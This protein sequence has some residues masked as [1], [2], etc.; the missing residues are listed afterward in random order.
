MP[1]N[2]NKKPHLP[3]IITWGWA[4]EMGK[5]RAGRKGIPTTRTSFYDSK[6]VFW[7][8]ETNS[9]AFKEAIQSTKTNWS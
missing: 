4:F 7:M 6:T 1:S 9:Y 8:F 5:G 2:S 3:Y